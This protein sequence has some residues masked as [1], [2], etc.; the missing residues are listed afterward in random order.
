M[1]EIH[2]DNEYPA[3]IFDF[4]DS[5]YGVDRPNE[6]YNELKGARQPTVSKLQDM[7]AQLSESEFAKNDWE[8]AITTAVVIEESYART[9]VN[10]IKLN[11]STVPQ[12]F[13]TYVIINRSCVI[14]NWTPFE[15]ST[16]IVSV[17]PVP[18]FLV[19]DI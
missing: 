10:D 16:Q 15:H 12:G 1:H 3:T 5:S 2:I 8:F 9:F 11:E 13:E 7:R 19:A 18:T 6:I 4:A 17:Y 14:G